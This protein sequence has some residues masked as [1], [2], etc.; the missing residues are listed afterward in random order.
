MLCCVLCAVC[1]LMLC[2]SLCPGKL[3]RC[4]LKSNFAFITY[5]EDADAAEAVKQLHNTEVGG[6]R[7]NV[8]LT[9]SSSGKSAGRMYY[10]L[11]CNVLCRSNAIEL[12]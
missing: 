6:S 5:E 4:D 2:W 9:R 8:E 1:V 7:I 3:T 10:D 11:Y 12:N